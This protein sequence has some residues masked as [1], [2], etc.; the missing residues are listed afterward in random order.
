MIRLF[1]YLALL[2]VILL[3]AMACGSTSRRHIAA[4]LDDVESYINEH[5]DSALVV[6]EGLDSTALTT[7]ALRARYSLLHVM[8][9]DKCYRDI[10]VPGLLDPAAAWYEHHGTPDERMKAL[11]YQ[12]RIAQDW[13]DR[14]GAAVFYA[15]AEEYV[16]SV[17]DKHALGLLYLAQAS[18]YNAV[19]NIEQEKQCVEKALEVFRTTNDPIYESSLGDLAMVF[20][21]Q[22]EWALADSLYQRAINNSENYPYA[23]SLYLSNYARMKVQ[24][25]KEDPA[26]TIE[27]LDRKSALSGG[28]LIPKEAG[29]YAY[30]LA[31]VGEKSSSEKWKTQ[32]ESLTGK[33]HYDVLYWLMRMARLEGDAELAYHYLAEIRSGEDSIISE[34]LSDSVTRSLQDYY[35]QAALQERERK[36]RLGLLAMAVV[37]L[38]FLFVSLLIIKERRTRAELDRLLSI[39]SSLEQE[40][41]AQENRVEVASTDISVRLEELRSQLQQERLARMRKAGCYEY[42]MWMEKKSRFSDQE[43]VKRLRKDL[44]D[45]CALESDYGKLAGRLDHVLDG[46][47]S[48]LKVDLHLVGRPEE[49]RF[50]CYWLIGL[51]PDMIA[52]LMDITPNNVYVKTHRLIERIRHL[53]K[54][55]YACLIKG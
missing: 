40:L 41:I 3:L 12:G 22:K 51:K 47:Y 26:G 35:E 55:E 20:H 50:L 38:L 44:Q 17:K 23:L 1:K 33:D 2:L 13:K 14:N 43:V 8:A 7:R 4:T 24:Q 19:Y 52:E 16:G 6:L 21:S 27:L 45:V 18:I 53:N 9:L 28:G 30:A 31:L 36:Y 25:P 11:Y 10:T 54:P 48:R 32:L 46:M 42:W 49:E 15:R 5:P 29:A 34:T 39:R 37:F